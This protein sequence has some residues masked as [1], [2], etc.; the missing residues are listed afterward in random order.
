MLSWLRRR[1]REQILSQPFPQSWLD[2]L[3][4]RVT[5]YPLLTADEQRRLREDVQ[6]FV[7]EKNWEGCNGLELNDE[8]RVVVAGWACLLVLNRQHEYFSNVK[9][10]L[11]YPAT[12]VVPE[13]RQEG[14][15][16]GSETMLG[17]AHYRGP[18]IL[19]WKDVRRAGRLRGHGENVVVHEFAHQLD[20]LDRSIDGTP[21]LDSRE[22]YQAWTE[23]MSEEYQRLAADWNAGRPTVLDPYGTQNEAEFFAIATE[24]FFGRPAL[25]ERE[26]ARLYE[27]LRRYYRQDT[28]ARMRR[29]AST[30]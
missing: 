24:A 26:H 4:T 18:V 22:E 8:M 14:L 11:L 3:A 29:M 6:I 28:A 9:S 7:A 15:I 12:Y 5:H 25:L 19:S 30:A 10:I 1:R 13:V 17:Q 2:A 27:L 16:H 23:V 21:P 20:M